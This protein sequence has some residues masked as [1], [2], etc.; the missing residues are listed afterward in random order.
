MEKETKPHSATMEACLVSIELRFIPEN[1]VSTFVATRL[2][3]Q[4][5]VNTCQANTYYVS[6]CHVFEREIPAA[7][8]GMSSIV[9]PSLIKHVSLR[10]VCPNIV[11]LHVSFVALQGFLHWKV[12]LL[13]SWS[14]S[15]QQVIGVL[16]HLLLYLKKDALLITKCHF[17]LCNICLGNVCLSIEL[18]LSQRF[19]F[20]AFLV[21]DKLPHWSYSYL[22]D[23]QI[24]DGS[25]CTTFIHFHIDI[26]VTL[27]FPA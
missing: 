16:L 26:K 20:T 17:S 4:Q 25:L 13:S 21:D 27:T 2:L 18:T 19:L 23:R 10:A 5:K 24:Q 9:C 6:D 1:A 11:V 15:D 14:K 8:G 7:K 3:Q 12:Q 22:S